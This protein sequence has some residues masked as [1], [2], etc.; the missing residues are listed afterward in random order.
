MDVAITILVMWLL[1]G[2]FVLFAI[3]HHGGRAD[4]S[5]IVAIL[6]LAFIVIFWPAVVW[7]HAGIV[8]RQSQPPSG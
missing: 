1:T 2:G 6:A 5:G 7:E 8:C 3:I 4:T